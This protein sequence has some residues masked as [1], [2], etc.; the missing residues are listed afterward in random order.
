MYIEKGVEKQKK[1]LYRKE[2]YLEREKKYE[3]GKIL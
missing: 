3:W 1:S 2:L